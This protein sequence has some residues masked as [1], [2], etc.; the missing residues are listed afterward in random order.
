MVKA[1]PPSAFIVAQSNLLLQFEVVTLDP[2]AELGMVD[3]AFE[4][5]V[6]CHRGEPVVIRFG[7]ALWPLDH[8][9][10]P[11]GGF[12]PPGTV[13]PGPA[14]PPGKP[15]GQWRV[16]AV[17]PG[18]RLPVLGGKRQGQRLCRYRLIRLL[19]GLTGGGG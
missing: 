13:V 9:P 4:A 2:P 8:H 18:D 6:G 11:P 1:A 12:A 7:C 14:P 15:R 16:A 3:H 19:A 10:P 17:S 5:D